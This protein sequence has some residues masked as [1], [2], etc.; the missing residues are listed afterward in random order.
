M[1]RTVKGVYTGVGAMGE[2]RDGSHVYYIFPVS[3]TM[4]WSFANLDLLPNAFYQLF[5]LE[6]YQLFILEFY[7][8]F[9][10]E[11]YQLFILEFY[12]LFILEFCHT[13]IQT[14]RF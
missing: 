12:Q 13:G 2:C 9:I 10:L 3:G 5:I 11:F 4:F 6:F 1:S 7:Q 8:L 14:A